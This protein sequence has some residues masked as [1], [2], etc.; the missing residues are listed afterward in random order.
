MKQKMKRKIRKTGEIIEVISYGGNV[1]RNNVLDFVSYIDSKGKEHPNEKMNFY[2]DLKK[3]EE[4]N[5]FDDVH[6][7][8]EVERRLIAGMMMSAMISN[9]KFD[10]TYLTLSKNGL[11]DLTKSAVTL[12]D[13]LIVELN[14]TKL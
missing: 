12:T 8:N 4:S 9:P 11:K 7:N 13:A 10:T 6:M 1:V 2:W 14:K 5:L 3:V